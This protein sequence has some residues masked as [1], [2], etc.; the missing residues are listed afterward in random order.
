MHVLP[1]LLLLLLRL[2]FINNFSHYLPHS[3]SLVAAP[4]SPFLTH[5]I[6]FPT[7][8]LLS[9]PI[10][11]RISPPLTLHCYCFCFRCCCCC[12]CFTRWHF[13]ITPL[14]FCFCSSFFT[15]QSLS[16]LLGA[17]RLLEVCGYGRY[18]S[19]SLTVGTIG[20]ML[21]RIF[22]SLLRALTSV[23]LPGYLRMDSLGCLIWFV[24][25]MLLMRTS[26]ALLL[27]L[28]FMESTLLSLRLPMRYLCFF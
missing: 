9:I 4:I 7:I 13:T 2:S 23:M 17:M 21:P 14:P 8:Q 11:N 25:L 5:L 20:C 24:L 28:C 27:L 10:P 22:T 6:T 15:F 16:P 19:P 3:L 12:C 18:R 26:L 1:C